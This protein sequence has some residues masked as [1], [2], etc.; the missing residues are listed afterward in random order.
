MQ[1]V[2]LVNEP[3]E[4]GDG[5]VALVGGGSLIDGE[6][7]G[8]DCGAHL[9]DGVLIRR[10]GGLVLKDEHGAQFLGD[11]LRRA[12]LM[13]EDQQFL[14]TLLSVCEPDMLGIGEREAPCPDLCRLVFGEGPQP[15]FQPIDR[16]LRAPL[17]PLLLW[18]LHE[19]R[20]FVVIFLQG[21]FEGPHL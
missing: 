3:L 10:G 11:A 18:R 16:V 1:V 6:S 17:E 14:L 8:L 2:E 7:H 21:F 20:G 15:V 9:A 13:E 5:V 12:W 19:A 4:L